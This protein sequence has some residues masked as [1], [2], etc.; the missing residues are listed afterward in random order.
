MAKLIASI[1]ILLFLGFA[2]TTYAQTENNLVIR[3]DLGE[4]K[5]FLPEGQTPELTPLYENMKKGEAAFY[6]WTENGNVFGVGFAVIEFNNI[7]GAE[8]YFNTMKRT[9]SED[10]NIK[11]Y[12][13]LDL[14]YL[15]GKPDYGRHPGWIWQSDKY[16]IFGIG[17]VN[18]P[19][20][21]E[22]LKSIPVSDI[23]FPEAPLDAYIEKYPVNYFTC[24]TYQTPPEDEY[25]YNPEFDDNGCINGYTMKKEPVLQQTTEPEENIETTQTEP[26][27]FTPQP[28]PSYSSYPTPSYTIQPSPELPKPPQT[29]VPVSGNIV[30]DEQAQGMIIKAAVQLANVKILLQELKSNIEGVAN[31]YYNSGSTEKYDLWVS[32]IEM[33][34]KTIDKVDLI[35]QELKITKDVEGARVK[36]KELIAYVYQI[37][38]Q[39]LEAI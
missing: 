5:Y 10:M 34:Q 2:Y 9:I 12:K 36:I 30:K 31:F 20:S 35:V 37:A 19:K 32:V 7:A 16:M 29:Q 38:D 14:H 25:Q 11:K 22:D 18:S 21:L 33:F 13:E 24:P 1:L 17:P 6:N 28:E 26:E 8:N 4:Y 3:S 27:I 23:S 39:I 15:K